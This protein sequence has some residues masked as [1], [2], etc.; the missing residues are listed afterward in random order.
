MVLSQSFPDKKPIYLRPI[1]EI[2]ADETLRDR[3][4]SFI[5]AT[6]AQRTWK[7][8]FLYSFQAQKIEHMKA[9]EALLDDLIAK[10]TLI[11]QQQKEMSETLRKQ[12]N[13][14]EVSIAGTMK[15]IEEL[16]RAIF[17]FNSSQPIP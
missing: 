8:K 3:A 2:L 5:P 4:H 17:K 13:Q 15:K 9:Q 16:N 11:L 10:K 14:A 7:L 6:E 12:I 1:P